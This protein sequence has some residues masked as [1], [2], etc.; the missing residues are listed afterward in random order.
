[1]EYRVRNV[2]RALA[3]LVVSFS[4]LTASAEKFYWKANGTGG[5]ASPDRWAK[6]SATGEPGVPTSGGTDALYISGGARAEITDDD[7]A[8]VATL[9]EAVLSGQTTVVLNMTTNVV[10]GMAFQGSKATV[11]K[12]NDNVVDMSNTRSTLQV[13]GGDIVV[14]NGV[15]KLGKQ[16][17]QYPSTFHVWKP[18]VLVLPHGSEYFTAGVGGDGTIRYDGT[19]AQQLKFVGDL[20]QRPEYSDNL[21]V[22]PPYDFSGVFSGNPDNSSGGLG[23]VAGATF[24]REGITCGPFGQRFTGTNT[25]VNMRTPRFHRG[26]FEVASVGSKSGPSSL[27]NY[28]RLSF[29]NDT[30]VADDVSG[31]VY[32]GTNDFVTARG[33]DLYYRTLGTTVVFDGGAHGG[34]TFGP[35]EGIY[36]ATGDAT[37]CYPY[38]TTSRLVLRGSNTVACA[39]TTSMVENCPTNALAIVKQGSGTWHIQGNKAVKGP[40]QVEQ[41]RLRFDSLAA[42]GTQCALGTATLLYTNWYGSA[43]FADFSVPYAWLVGDGRTDAASADLATLEYSGSATGFA[44]GR[45]L[46]VRGA[47]RI[48][49]G[50]SALRLTGAF[51]AAAGVN[52]LVLGGTSADNLYRDVTNGVGVLKVVKEGSGTW[53]LTGDVTLGGGVEVRAGKLKV[54]NRYSWYRLNMK[55]PVGATSDKVMFGFRTFGMWDADG[56]LLTAGMTGHDVD[57]KTESLAVGET[58]LALKTDAYTNNKAAAAWVAGAMNYSDVSDPLNP[59]SGG[60][61]RMWLN[62]A[63]AANILP[64]GSDET[65]WVRGVIRLAEDAAP[66]A[67]YD[68]RAEESSSVAVNKNWELKAF[69]LD[70]SPDGFGWTS[71]HSVDNNDGW[72]GAG[73]WHSVKKSTRT[74]ADG[75]R[76]DGKTHDA[77]K[78]ITIASVRVD[79]GAE[80]EVDPEANV[81]VQGFEYD[82]AAGGGTISGGLSLA[83]GGVLRVTG[84][85]P[86]GGALDLPVD[87]SNVEGLDQLSSWSVVLNGSLSR[88]SVSATSS[89]FKIQ[90]P[91]ALIIIR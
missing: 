35:G 83:A 67:A 16:V 49:G 43:Q 90:P 5:W 21:L 85:V 62:A 10:L 82:R 38:G 54:S 88:W 39:I 44:D 15:L 9:Y 25:T 7:A 30:K 77:S 20:F 47:G 29:F 6:G 65:T 8:F 50:S 61:F 71:L 80:L 18:G 14:S 34:L 89:G 33:A 68:M 84:N 40:F 52:S 75:F 2:C 60:Y 48:S 11:L 63:T 86:K 59:K 51:S 24:A 26:F 42:L 27:G 13:R 70:G 69:G 58:A 19:S 32:L 28:D 76:L 66:V 31:F 79:G 74:K 36:N 57:G 72:G 73:N 45:H 56:N 81:T 22:K 4:V 17:G 91:G 1:M 23:L 3:A 87:L 53:R 55:E 46:A 12:L 78:S 64:R 37:H 41:G